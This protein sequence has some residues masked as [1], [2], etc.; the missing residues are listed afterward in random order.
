MKS[1]AI[2][3]IM[4]IALMV[5]SSTIAFATSFNSLTGDLSANGWTMTDGTFGGGFGTGLYSTYTDFS[6]AVHPLNLNASGPGSFTATFTFKLNNISSRVWVGVG[7]AQ[8]DRTQQRVVGYNGADS[9][10]VITSSSDDFTP[11][12][13]TAVP[14]ADHEYKAVV[15]STD[16]TTISF[17]I[18]DTLGNNIAGPT[19]ATLSSRAAYA[20][21]QINDIGATPGITTSPIVT[22]VRFVDNSPA[23]SATPTP[24]ATPS[25]KP[26]V[27]YAAIKNFYAN[28]PVVHMSN[29][30][31]V[32][33]ADGTV[34]QVITGAQSAATPTPKPVVT[35]TAVPSVKPPTAVPT[36]VPTTPSPTKT[37]SPGFEIVLA[38]LGMIAALALIS[39]KK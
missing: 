5:V 31:I 24:T 1:K 35:A 6:R 15:S 34:K 36:T 30:S 38:A 19:T 10:F 16:G 17:T 26:A 4:L 8:S 2:I 3:S 21:I 28:Y 29:Q 18:Q 39:R 11:L 25:V 20:V 12:S 7:S 23:P 27:D 14:D 9:H 37:Q 22:Q 32:Y 13:G 33:N